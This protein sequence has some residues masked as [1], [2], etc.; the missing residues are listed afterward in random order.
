M[1]GMKSAPFDIS[2]LGRAF[3]T[4]NGG[5]SWENV[6]SSPTEGA[7]FNSVKFANH[8]NGIAISDPVDDQVFILRI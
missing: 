5:D 6:Y 8:T 2:P 4:R 3:I 7:F 1:P